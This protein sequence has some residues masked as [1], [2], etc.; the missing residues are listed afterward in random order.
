MAYQI[1]N[2]ET[3]KEVREGARL[4]ISE[5]FPQRLAE[6]IVPV[7]EVNPKQLRICNIVKSASAI[8][9]TSGTIYTTLQIK[10]FI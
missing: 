6:A 3:I 1:Q 2:S 5:G 9:A 7:M 8:N 10:I 4:S